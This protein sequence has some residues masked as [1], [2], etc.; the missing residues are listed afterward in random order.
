MEEMKGFLEGY[1]IL[2]LTD[3]MGH[4]CGRILGDMG[5]DVI[6]IE[7][8]GGDPARNSGPFYH[9][10]PHPEKGLYWFYANA[11]KRGITLNL[12]MVDGRDIFRQLVKDADVIIESFQPSYL[13]KLSLGYSSLT[14]IKPDII[15]SS[16]TPFGQGGPYAH[17]RVT[18]LI[19]ASM[20]G[21]VYVH[22]DEDRA[23]VRIS[24]PQVWFL[25]GQHAAM[26]TI[27]ALYHRELTGEGQMMDTSIQEAVVYTLTYH[28][29]VWEQRQA[30]RVRGGPFFK[31]PRPLPLGPLKARQIFPCQDGEVALSFQGS[32]R[33][34]I[35]SCQ[36]LIAWANEEGH[37]LGIRDF[38]WGTWDSSTMEQSEQDFLDKE[39]S[40]FLL[41]KTKDELLRGAVE[42]RILLAPLSTAAD[43]PRNPQLA[44]RNFWVELFHPELD[45]TLTYPGPF[46][47]VDQCPQ[48]IHRRAPGIGEHNRDI[49]GDELGMSNEKLGLLKAQGVI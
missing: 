17:Y 47:K 40:E 13:E 10:D 9:D 36:Q 35:K 14:E 5:A 3:E 38:D 1:R 46:V 31:R 48:R 8:P 4:L 26:G 28:L 21:M 12:K 42:R 15:L 25:G 6:K 18:D 43:L 23:P 41:T 2:D 44:S 24:V 20:G 27:T 30:K 32:T 34:G 33:A 7:P 45:D 39:I 11:N 22:G 16:I 49:Y 29:Q 37:A 19:A